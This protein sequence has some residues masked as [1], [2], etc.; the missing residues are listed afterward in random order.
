MS[1]Y[2]CKNP[3]HPEHVSRRY[4]EMPPDGFCPD[5]DFGA[6]VLEQADERE[7]LQLTEGSFSPGGSGEIGLCTLICDVS[8]SMLEPPFSDNP[9]RKIDL[10]AG[11]AAKGIADLYAVS[12]PGDA[13]VAVTV[14]GEE[15]RVLSDASGIPFLKSIEAIRRDFPDARVLGNFLRDAFIAASRDIGRCTNI[16][17]ALELARGIHSGALAGSL[18][19]YG[20]PDG[21]ALKEHDILVKRT[22]TIEVIP[23]VRAVIYSDGAHNANAALRNPFENDDFSTLIS[24]FFGDGDG[25][26]A[27]TMRGLSAV[28]PEHDRPG[29]FLI[30]SPSGYATLRHLF[31]MASGAS[32]FCEQCLVIETAAFREGVAAAEA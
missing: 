12:H 3:D 25:A 17:A 31:R 23:N 22:S 15:A 5:C 2:I 20:G 10:I 28:C 18:E 27:A 11:A 14:F 16:T 19:T 8:Y 29:F 21:F 4:D 32:G 26:G 24:M 30:D 7:L 9:A 6:A 1:A 13:F